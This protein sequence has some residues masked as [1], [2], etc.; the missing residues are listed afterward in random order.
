A[1]DVIVK[2]A[3]DPSSRMHFEFV[4]VVSE[5][6]LFNPLTQDRFVQA[7]DGGSA[8]GNFEI[9]KGF[10]LISNNFWSTD[11]KRYLFGVTP[12]FIVQPN[13]TL[14]H[15]FRFDDPGN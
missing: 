8:N 3:F 9:I 2:I 6:R 4:E 11:E 1:P 13:E 12:T 7:G 15:S 14:K 10:R 5:V